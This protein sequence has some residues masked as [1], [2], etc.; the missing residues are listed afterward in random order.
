MGTK[1]I[2]QVLKMFQ[3]IKTI[4]PILPGP[5]PG[6]SPGSGPSQCEYT[7]SVD[8]VVLQ[9]RRFPRHIGQKSPLD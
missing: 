3:V 2:L 8:S 6:P 5:C 9:T 1:P 7:I 4:Q